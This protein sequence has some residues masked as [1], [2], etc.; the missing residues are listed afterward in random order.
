MAKI[1]NN[2]SCMSIQDFANNHASLV[3]FDH[4][5]AI[6]NWDTTEF[7]LS[8]TPEEDTVLIFK[9]G[10]L[11]EPG[12][13]EDYIVEGDVVKMSIPK[14]DKEEKLYAFYRKK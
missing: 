1:N 7:K 6:G 10:L 3:K 4:L 13:N 14:Y 12:I 9:N 5:Q 2:Q 8:Y 11:M